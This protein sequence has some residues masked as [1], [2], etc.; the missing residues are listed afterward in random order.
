MS[1]RLNRSFH[2]LVFWPATNKSE[3]SATNDGWDAFVDL[4]VETR[5]WQQEGPGRSTCRYQD[6]M[7]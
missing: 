3:V 5:N 6:N 7:S 2:D 1:V 4:L